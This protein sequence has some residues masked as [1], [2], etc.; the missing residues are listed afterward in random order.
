MANRFIQFKGRTFSKDEFENL[1]GDSL[2]QDI[3][4]HVDAA[5]DAVVDAFA[6]LK[7]DMIAG[8]A[9]GRA[10]GAKTQREPGFKH[11]GLALTPRQET[12]K[13]GRYR[14]RIRS[15]VEVEITSLKTD[16]NN[17]FNA[18]DRGIPGRQGKRSVIGTHQ[19]YMRFPRY[20]GTTLTRTGTSLTVTPI[21][22]G[23]DRV[24]AKTNR[25][26]RV[27]DDWV[28]VRTVQP[29]APFRL[30]ERLRHAARKQLREVF[31]GTS[32]A[33]WLP[34]RLKTGVADV[35]ITVQDRED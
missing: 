22:M 34:E 9:A 16:E 8:S 1:I 7:K 13:I 28:T 24:K 31:A 2:R 29:V 19:N 32:S 4:A 10:P 18:M 23:K 20:E 26:G 33:Q 27:I 3:E 25:Q 14:G 17:A 11:L 6:Q 5:V 12:I 35:K 15:V 30:F 21:K